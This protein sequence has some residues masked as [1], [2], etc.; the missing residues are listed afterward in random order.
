MAGCH[1]PAMRPVHSDRFGATVG[2]TVVKRLLAVFLCLAYMS[3]AAAASWW[4]ADW[5]ARKKI[6]LNTTEQGAAI[7]EGVGPVVVPIRLHTGNFLFAD[8][9]PDGS[10]IRFVAADD[11]TPLKHHIELFD[12]TNQLAV[13]WVQV[14]RVN[15]GKADEFLWLYSG[16]AK[17]GA[18]DDAKGSYDGAQLL[19]VHGPGRDGV[20]LA[21]STAFAN[22]LTATNV[23]AG[24]S[25]LIAG[26][27][28]FTGGPLR[29]APVPAARVLATGGFTFSAWVRPASE[30]NAELF[31]WGP[32]KIELRGNQVTASFGGALAAGGTVAPDA[33]THIAVTAAERLV[34]YV[35]GVEVAAQAMKLTEISGDMTIGAGFNGQLDEVGV[36]NVARPAA[37]IQLEAAQSAEG[38]LLTYGE[39]E[40]TGGEHPNYL[41]VLV[42][43]LTVDA[44]V[45]I[46]ILMLM[47]AVSFVVMYMKAVFL[48][49]TSRANAVF[50]DQFDKLALDVVAL[51]SNGTG[52][53]IVPA[54]TA[55]PQLEQS[56]TLYSMYATAVRELSGRAV[57]QG[58]AIQRN[59]LST[60]TLESI[61]ASV[62]ATMVRE[63][64]RLD[65]R[66]V[67]LTIS[68]SGGPFLGLLG[69]VVG[70]MIVF[71]AVAAA[72]D[73]N[74][75]AIAPG[76]AAALLATVAGL[77]VAIPCLFGYNYLA[78][79]VK[80]VNAD[81]QVFGDV[82]VTR[83]AERFAPS[84]PYQL[85]AE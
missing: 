30:Q 55:T 1:Q 8:A 29:V 50:L 15:P 9:K 28:T 49:R 54:I 23:A 44:W 71:A 14:P 85:E 21:D 84:A 59:G 42:D 67:L 25:G 34:L 6:T 62:D 73:V 22:P 31:A 45:V 83:L 60:Q 58:A 5:T 76:I 64:Q 2:T 77:G 37:W 81:M 57:K 51:R 26:D 12:S 74:I 75:N 4:N 72:G 35:N 16:N 82:I 10:D 65:S 48:A 80:S 47:M 38:R 17:V 61:R 13:L 7:K 27:L 43:N 24:G 69:T 18:A 46:I 40:L 39:P 66:L 56:S 20:S 52:H 33:W 41:K 19:V 68:I 32:M 3:T 63:R 53:E 78:S 79:R 70:V 11:K 36:A